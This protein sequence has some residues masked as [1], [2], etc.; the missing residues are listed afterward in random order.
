MKLAQA[1]SPPTEVTGGLHVPARSWLLCCAE[2]GLAV[3]VVALDLLIPALVLVTLALV[4]VRL[5]HQSGR[6]LG[7]VRLAEPAGVATS[8][9][10]L[11]VLWTLVVIGVTIPVLEHLTGERQDVSQ[12]AEVEGNLPLLLVMLA[13]AWTLGAFVEELAFRGW[14]MTR[15]REVMPAGL[16]GVVVA[17]ILSAALFGLAHTE[18]GVIGVV[19]TALDGVY[20]AV[21]RLR[22]RSLWASVLA[23]GFNNTIGL[24]TF[25]VVGPV[26][27]L[28]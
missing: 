26:Y 25:F 24:I 13:L 15:V 21:V 3:A 10:F 27:G 23:H 28:W 2:I 19:V 17:T 12:F 14:L 1:S 9:L 6:D 18:Q 22:F 4:S 8:V 11:S 20:F 7:L 16:A 5:R